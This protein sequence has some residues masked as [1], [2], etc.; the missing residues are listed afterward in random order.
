MQY[1]ITSIQPIN[2]VHPH[3]I[4]S[5]PRAIVA[6]SAPAHSFAH[7]PQFAQSSTHARHGLF[8]GRRISLA[9]LK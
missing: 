1:L 8:R 2:S 5:T 6:S 3:K 4:L 9:G 7:P